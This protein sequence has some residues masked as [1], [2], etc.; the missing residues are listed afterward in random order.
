MDFYYIHFCI[1]GCEQESTMLL[2]C[3]IHSYTDIFF[4]VKVMAIVDSEAVL[5]MPGTK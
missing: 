5:G 3:S 4:M 2:P 1:L